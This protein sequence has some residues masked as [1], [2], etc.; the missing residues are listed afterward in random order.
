MVSVAFTI[1]ESDDLVLRHQY[2]YRE[3]KLP[4]IVVSRIEA[5]VLID[6]RKISAMYPLNLTNY[7]FLCNGEMRLFEYV[8][9]VQ[10]GGMLIYVA[11]TF[12]LF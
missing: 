10:A 4:I 6:S 3:H 9:Y 2:A 5:L 11:V 1:P 8:M 12:L 7:Y